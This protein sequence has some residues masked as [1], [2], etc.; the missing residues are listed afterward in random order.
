MISQL[1]LKSTI[2][3]KKEGLRNEIA[4]NKLR[5]KQIDDARKIITAQRIADDTGAWKVFDLMAEM[6]DYD[7]REAVRVRRELDLVELLEEAN[8][9]NG[10]C[11]LG[12]DD[13]HEKFYIFYQEDG[14]EIRYIFDLYSVD[15]SELD[16]KDIFPDIVNKAIEKIKN[17]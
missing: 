17:N 9:R 11:L 4:N 1:D 15:I 6:L 14:E 10:Y 2:E 16:G 7:W 12:E 3:K 8:D 5:Q 13:T